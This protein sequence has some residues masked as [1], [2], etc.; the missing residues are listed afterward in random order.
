MAKWGILGP[1]L[2]VDNEKE[3]GQICQKLHCMV[4]ECMAEASDH[5]GSI[6]KTDLVPTSRLVGL[7][8]CVQ[9]AIEKKPGE[10]VVQECLDRLG[11]FL[12]SIQATKLFQGKIS[13]VA[14]STKQVPFYKAN[15]HRLLKIFIQK[16][17]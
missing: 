13:E 5:K 3:D 10:L 6:L 11:Q 17:K 1:I 8:E 2:T 7:V 15:G 4:L 16:S 9:N 14:S 12:L